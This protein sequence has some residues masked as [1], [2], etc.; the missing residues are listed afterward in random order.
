MCPCLP[1]DLDAA[2]HAGDLFCTALRGQRVDLQA[3]LTRFG[4]QEVTAAL[5]RYL[6]EVGDTQNLALF[7][8]FA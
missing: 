7:A 3:R 2:Q 1:S 6:G 4:H 5:N 8:E